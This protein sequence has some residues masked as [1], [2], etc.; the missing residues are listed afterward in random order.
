[1]K[2]CPKDGTLMSPK[3]MRD[4]TTALVCLKCGRKEK[5]RGGATFKVKEKVEHAPL[6]RIAV[7]EKEV[8]I[9]PVT[10]AHCEKCGNNQAEWWTQQ[11]RS[12]DEP[13]TRFYRCTK[14]KHTWREYS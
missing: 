14:C 6:D 12:S 9:L 1:M 10:V 7:I 2:T 11:T 5:V 13:E 8:N 3:R 4:G